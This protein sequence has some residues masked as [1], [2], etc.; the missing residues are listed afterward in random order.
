M[1]QVTEAPPA[2]PSAPQPATVVA[3]VRGRLP[4]SFARLRD[5]ALVPVIVVLFIV[6]SFISP[7]FFS[8]DN[9]K[10]VLQEQTE[11]S[12]LVLAEALVLICGKF[13]LSLESTV[14]LAP[15]VACALTV[16]IQYR[17]LGIDW[18]GWTAIPICLGVG[19]AIGAI[20][21]LLI[22]RFRLSA[23]IVTL[24]MLITLRGLQVGITNG[25]SLFNL[26]TSFAY[27]G[28][29]E[30]VGIPASIWI[31]AVLFAVGILALGFLRHGRAL[32][33]IGGNV[34]A[35]RAAGIRT[36]RTVWAVFIL[37]GLLAATAG[38]L[39]SGRLGSVA[40]AQG[41]GEIFTVFAAAVIGGVS[42]DGGKGTIFGALTGVLVLGLVQN[43]LTFAGV[44]GT[45]LDAVYGGV[46]LAALVLARI[47]S[48]KAQD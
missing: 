34:D 37:A 30:W 4:S 46:I 23:F 5:L 36:E 9:I 27:L 42:L 8:L 11:L 3:R 16:S 45:W 40:A 20:N 17:G 1:A 13:D 21:G 15:A 38:M 41:Q 26:P 44:P 32:Y 33:A 48:G 43:I 14:G 28:T 7:D 19:V 10:H 18:P 2:P 39:L 22:M 12:L 31:C 47:T 24:G 29:A 6:G 25:S 35:A